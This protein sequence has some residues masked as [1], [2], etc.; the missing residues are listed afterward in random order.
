[1]FAKI[2]SELK[3]ISGLKNCIETESWG[4]VHTNLFDVYL[5]RAP[6]QP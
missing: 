3:S 2:I 5:P 4:F 6:H 1:M